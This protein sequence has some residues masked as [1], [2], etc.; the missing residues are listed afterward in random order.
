MAQ[1]VEMSKEWFKHDTNA[2]HD[3]KIV[4]MRAKYGMAGYG[5]WWALIE[6]LREIDDYKLPVKHLPALCLDFDYQEIHDFIADCIGEFDLLCSDGDYIWSD[7]LLV[8]ME[9]YN[10]LVAQRIEAGRR[11]GLSKSQASAKQKGSDLIRLDKSRVDKKK[12]HGECVTL[13]EEAYKILCYQYGKVSVDSKIDDI[14]NYCLSK[15][16]RYKDYAATI[17]AWFK[18]DGVLAKAKPKVCEKG[19]FYTGDVCEACI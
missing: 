2:R 16:K 1:E 10:E 17:R 14:N 9:A 3:V 8:R 12:K 19:H 13:D 15:G 7:S 18:K 4:L 11:G 5:A 6:T